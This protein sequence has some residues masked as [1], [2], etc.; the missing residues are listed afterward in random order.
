MDGQSAP[1]VQHHSRHVAPP[2]RL[3]GN[4]YGGLDVAS[5]LDAGLAAEATSVRHVGLGLSLSLVYDFRLA[6][7]TA[8]DRYLDVRP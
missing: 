3:C 2:P 5:V 1:G 7:C 6:G 4:T 8:E